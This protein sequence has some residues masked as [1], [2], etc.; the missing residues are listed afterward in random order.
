MNW[1][2]ITIAIVTGALILMAV[3]SVASTSTGHFIKDK[4]NETP[5]EQPGEVLINAGNS[6]MNTLVTVLMFMLGTVVIAVGIY[7]KF[8]P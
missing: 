5:L 4:F 2:T 3:V 6:L 1:Q 7:L 8:H